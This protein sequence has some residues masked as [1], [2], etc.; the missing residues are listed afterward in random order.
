M[1]NPWFWHQWNLVEFTC[2]RYWVNCSVTT[3]SVSLTV[4]LWS[5]IGMLQWDSWAQ[6]ELQWSGNAVIP[7]F[8]YSHRT[9]TQ[10]D[11]TNSYNHCIYI[12]SPSS[13][14]HWYIAT[15]LSNFKSITTNNCSS[16]GEDEPDL[17][18]AIWLSV[19][20]HVQNIHLH[21]S[22]FFP[23]CL[24]GDIERD[25]IKPGATYIL[26]CL[27]VSGLIEKRRTSCFTFFLNMLRIQE[28]THRKTLFFFL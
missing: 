7:T 19:V 27:T 5:F 24:H 2:V 18:E 17:K 28:L 8:P 14:K 4:N 25:W 15:L 26:K 16:T 21:D 3:W 12:C 22:P 23:Y 20:N 10:P 11:A 13:Y 6:C 1:I 9:Q